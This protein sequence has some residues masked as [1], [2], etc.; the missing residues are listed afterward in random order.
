MTAYRNDFLVTKDI[1]GSGSVE[2]EQPFFGYFE[3]AMID[4]EI[5]TDEDGDIVMMEVVY[6]FT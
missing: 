5:L 3:P 6:D 1:G 2:G 4:H